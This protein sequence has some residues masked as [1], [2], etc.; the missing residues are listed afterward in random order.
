MEEKLEK[1]VSSG[2]GQ[3]GHL[4]TVW[5]GGLVEGREAAE[6]ADQIVSILVTKKLHELLTLVVRGEDAGDKGEGET[7][8]RN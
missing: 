2:L 6:T 7:F 5:P 3:G 1:N 8:K 4:Q